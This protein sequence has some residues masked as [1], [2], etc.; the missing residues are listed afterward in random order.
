MPTTHYDI[1]GVERTASC[2]EVEKAYQSKVNFYLDLSEHPTNHLQRL[3]VAKDVLCDEVKRRAYDR[4]LES[5]RATATANHL[6]AMVVDLQRI[7]LRESEERANKR[8]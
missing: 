5:N 8:K 6:G 7:F 1:L 4:K 2:E 3:S